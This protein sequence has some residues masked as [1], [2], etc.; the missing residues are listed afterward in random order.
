VDVFKIFEFSI[1]YNL[2]AQRAGVVV[3][4]PPTNA[5]SVEK[6]LVVA[7][8]GVDDILFFEVFKADCAVS[9]FLVSERIPF[10]ELFPDVDDACSYS[11]VQPLFST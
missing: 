3:H 10:I 1:R 9:H 6:V 2:P 11:I 8:Q 4:A 7:R 5:S